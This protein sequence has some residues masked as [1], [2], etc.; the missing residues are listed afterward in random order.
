ML[1]LENEL[2]LEDTAS[3]AERRLGVVG[4]NERINRSHKDHASP[5]ML[6][7]VSDLP[8]LFLWYSSFVLEIS[9]MRS[10]IIAVIVA[11]VAPHVLGAAIGPLDQRTSFKPY[12]FALNHMLTRTGDPA[13]AGKESSY[14]TVYIR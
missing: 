11:V 8:Y 10:G 13:G 12:Q 9:K 2:D 7:I 3:G 4:I 6:R 1:D 5:W 14:R